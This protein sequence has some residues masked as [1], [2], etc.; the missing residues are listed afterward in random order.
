[1]KFLYSKINYV[2]RIFATGFCF[3]CFGLGGI[4]MGY[5][6]FPLVRLTTL[7]SVVRIRRT[8]Y[9]IHLS[10]RFFCGMMQFLGVGRFTFIGFEKLKKDQGLIIIS[11]H[12]TLIDYVVIVSRLKQCNIIVKDALW[13]NPY[14]KQVIRS[15]GYIPNRHSSELLA[16]VK[17]SLATGNN[18]LVF[19]EG[20]RTVPG[21]EIALKRGAAQLALRLQAPVRAIKI[22]F[23]ESGLAKGDKWYKVPSQKMDCKVEVGTLIEPM[24]YLDD[25]DFPSLAARKLTR[26]FEDVLS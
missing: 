16:L 2:W 6:I 3:G 24:D 21:T 5:L 15:A 11:N 20:T 10:F 13:H 17:D 4:V 7:S 8:Q 18:L 1:M 23:T 25:S 14:V 12:P 19:P 9:L 26:H 22:T